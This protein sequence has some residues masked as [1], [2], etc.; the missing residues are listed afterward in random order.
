M[1][2]GR[3][4]EPRGVHGVD[5]DERQGLCSGQQRRLPR[6]FR[7]E[8]PARLLQLGDVP[9]GIGAQVRAERGRGADPAEQGA[10]RAVPQQAHVVDRISPGRHARDQ[11][12]HFHG[13]VDAACAAW[14]DVLR[15]QDAQPGAL[16]RAHHR[17]QAAVRHEIRVV[18]GCPSLRQAMQ[19]S[20]L[21]G[22]LSCST[23]EA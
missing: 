5:I 8:L 22:V 17:H 1:R 15:Y 21:T 6:Q 4:G 19:Q 18:E 12:R 23:T 11:A 10:H 20:H 7:E 16:G 14:A 2:D 3:D 9:P 13:G